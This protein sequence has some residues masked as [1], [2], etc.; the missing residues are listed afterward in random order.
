MVKLIIPV[1]AGRF[2]AFD[3]SDTP[4]KTLKQQ[5]Q[6]FGS[7]QISVLRFCFEKHILWNH[8]KARFKEET[9][10]YWLF[11]LKGNILETYYYKVTT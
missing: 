7:F 11:D 5:S 1:L 6:N 9:A 2:N 10:F 8:Q 3:T 4:L